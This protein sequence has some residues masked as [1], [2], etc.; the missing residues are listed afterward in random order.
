MAS[1][2]AILVTAFEPFGPIR[3]HVPGLRGNRSVD[4]LGQLKTENAGTGQLTFEVLP[5]SAAACT[6]LEDRLSEGPAGVLLMGEALLS[7][8]RLEPR[9]YDPGAQIGPVRLPGARSRTSAFAMAIAA[10]MAARGVSTA[11]GIGTYYCNS[12][13]WLALG[14]SERMA[15]RPAVFFHVG[16]RSN[17]EWQ[18]SHV[19]EALLRM[20]RTVAT[21]A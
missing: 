15:G 5:V 17:L 12:A 18:T 21:P 10:D 3:G 2:P 6:R 11:S 20:R 1:G 7:S 4:I 8:I 16:P 13:Y 19:R 14:W 9:A